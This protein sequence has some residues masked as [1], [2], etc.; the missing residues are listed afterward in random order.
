[1][2]SLEVVVKQRLAAISDTSPDDWFLVSRARHGMQVVFTTIGDKSGRGSIA[3]QAFTCITAV[4]PIIEAGF[5]PVY[6]DISS[7]NFSMDTK[8]L[9]S[10]LDKET[11]IVVV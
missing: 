9:S 10:A 5:T 1:M 4:N 2:E 6:V 7:T 8:M 11:G 3:T